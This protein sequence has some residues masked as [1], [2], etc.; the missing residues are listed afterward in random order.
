MISRSA[1]YRAPMWQVLPTLAAERARTP[2]RMSPVHP[3]SRAIS[4]PAGRS[5]RPSPDAGAR[6]RERRPQADGSPRQSWCP[7]ER[8][9]QAHHQFDVCF[10]VAARHHEDA[11]R[12]QFPCPLNR[13][14]GPG[15][16]GPGERCAR[17]IGR[18]RPDRNRRPFDRHGPR[19]VHRPIANRPAPLVGCATEVSRTSTPP[20]GQAC[21]QPGAA[22]RTAR[23]GCGMS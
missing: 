7:P 1:A 21:Q 6:G 5:H 11:L 2:L 9:G 13:Q 17:S 18:A 4:A 16:N 3:L 15:Q 19:I 12:R 22:C 8:A 14:A 23:T 10:R 20:P